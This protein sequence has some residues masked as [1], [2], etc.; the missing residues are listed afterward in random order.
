MVLFCAL[1]FIVR[2]ENAGTAQSAMNPPVRTGRF[3][4]QHNS[5]VLI[6]S[7]EMRVYTGGSTGGCRVKRARVESD[8]L[9][10]RGF[11][12]LAMLFLGFSG[13]QRLAA[14]P[15]SGAGTLSG[16]VLGPDDKP[17]AH[18]AVTYQSGGGT[19]PHVVHTDSKGHFSIS[20]LKMDNYDLRASAK[21]VFSAWEK[22]VMVR[23]GKIQSVTLHLVFAKEMPEAYG[24]N[25]PKK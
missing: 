15:Q 19:A 7:M 13:T 17:V 6:Q 1:V 9:M 22:N 16:I 2:T 20:K 23:S 10:K 8:G 3:R 11:L 18:A 4:L 14:E 24:A 21:G 5:V 25:P 12:C